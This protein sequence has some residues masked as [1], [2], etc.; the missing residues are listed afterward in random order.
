M[1]SASSI[2]LRR[3]IRRGAWSRCRRP[4]SRA[5]SQ[6]P[7][8]KPRRRSHPQCLQ[9]QAGRTTRRRPHVLERSRSPSEAFSTR[10]TGDGADVIIESTGKLPVITEAISM[11]FAPAAPIL[12]FGIFTVTEGKLP[13][14]QLYYK[15]LTLYN[16][17]AA[18]GEDFPASIDLVAKGM[19][20]LGPLGHAPAPTGRPRPSHPN[21]RRRRRRPH[22]NHPRPQ[23]EPAQPTNSTPPFPACRESS[24]VLT[25]IAGEWRWSKAAGEY[26]SQPIA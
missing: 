7:R 16:S 6:G 25:L 14:Y 9:A 18:K 11:R 15:E 1:P 3:P 23:R 24:A 19:V 4:A 17:R 13:F 22:E 8:R 10:P 2:F 5:A 21:A 26:W 20:K 12:L